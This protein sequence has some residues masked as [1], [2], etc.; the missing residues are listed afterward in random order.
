[1]SEELAGYSAEMRRLLD[2]VC[3]AIDGLDEAQL[4]WR[5]SAPESNSAYIIARHALGNAEAWVLGI[6]C[7]QPVERD[8][9]AEFRAA[10]PDAAP[11]IDHARKLSDR[12]EQALAALPPTALD[13]PRDPPAALRGVGPAD[14]LTARQAL[15]LA[16]DHAATHV[17]EIQLTR[18][19]AISN[20]KS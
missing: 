10:G 1:M 7:G 12:I 17:G 15:M 16:I 6:A 19:L 2:K 5:P 3:G 20:A 9:A 18:A 11:L 8:R 13:E 14:P 4:N